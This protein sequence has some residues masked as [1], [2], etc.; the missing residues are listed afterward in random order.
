MKNYILI[1]LTI[2]AF[3]CNAQNDVTFEYD[4][5]EKQFLSYKPTQSPNITEKDFDYANMILKETKSRTKNNPENFNLADYFNILSAFL[6][7]KESEKNIKTA[8]EK[9]KN[10]DDSCEYVLSF[11]NS[12]TTNPK[13]DIIRA[14]YLNKLKECKSRSI[15]ETKFIIEE[16]CKSNSLN[17]DLVKK[18][19]QVNIDDQKYRNQSSRELSVEQKKMDLK[20]QKIIN[21]LYK[22]YK[23]YL[24]KS[25]VGEKF[26]HVMWAV[27]QHS[28]TEMMSDY[29]PIIQKAVKEKE[30]D[31]APLKMMIDRYYGLKYGYQI[32]GS[33]SGFGFELAD[34]K[35][36][37]AIEE[38]YKIQ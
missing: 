5:F 27:I 28:N 2:S 31:Q 35:T 13:Y 14:D 18:I 12:I 17:I 19:Q 29:L 21:S 4:N 37:K 6:T 34:E 25:L 36:R 24:G 33:Q 10:A 20:N 23:T 15:T 30:L 32:F 9:F 11:E 38:K 8:F 26:E 16:Y 1:I 7:L 22:E 3:N